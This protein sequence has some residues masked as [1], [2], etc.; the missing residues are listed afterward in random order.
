MCIHT[1]VLGA[2]VLGG[3][4]KS[5]NRASRLWDSLPPS[6]VNQVHGMAPFVCLCCLERLQKIPDPL[7]YGAN[8]RIA[9]GASGEG[10]VRK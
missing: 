1:D 10:I 3:V 6:L 4:V 8:T 5:L 7:K 9:G 2:V